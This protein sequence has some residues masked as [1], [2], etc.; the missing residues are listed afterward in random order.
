MYNDLPDVLI[1]DV[2]VD[3]VLQAALEP[4]PESVMQ[5]TPSVKEEAKNP[6][7]SLQMNGRAHHLPSSQMIAS[8]PGSAQFFAL[9][10]S[11]P[12]IS[13]S[14]SSS[15]VSSQ[16]VCDA[17]GLVLK[18]SSVFIRCAECVD[19]I[20]DLCVYCFGNGA[21][22]GSHKRSHA[23]VTVHAKSCQIF[24]H[25]KLISKL[26]IFQMLRIM[27]QVEKRGCFNFSDLEKSLAIAPGD[28]E[29]LYLEIVTLLSQ[30]D[31]THVGGSY[32]VEPIPEGLTGG[33]ANFNPLRDEFEHEYVPEA[34]TLLASVIPP[35]TS[36]GISNELISLFDGYNGILDERERRRKVLKS[37]KM[38]TLKDF[39]NVLKKRKTDE[40]E[41]FEKIRIFLRPALLA[42]SPDD[43]MS[44][45]E[46]LANSLTYRKRLID[47]VKRLLNLRRNGISSELKEALQFDLDRKK[48]N[49][50]NSRK[51]SAGPGNSIKIWTSLPTL[52]LDTSSSTSSANTLQG[53][54]RGTRGSNPSIP[55]PD[56]NNRFMTA[57]E[58]IQGLP[59]GSDA[60]IE[61]CTELQIA[62]QHLKAIEIAIHS[63][64]R[65]RGHDAQVDDSVLLSL[66]KEG[67]FGTIRR[68]LLAAQGLPVSAVAQ[69]ILS[70]DEMKLKL[71]QYCR[72]S[73]SP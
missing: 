20:I 66:I 4:P 15:A 28:G 40:K 12:S 31:E 39:F 53:I 30:C 32:Q 68:Y 25:S 41:M 60:P 50:I 52:N 2:F 11:P 10:S 51:I 56:E 59:G 69:N 27:E 67:V 19:P 46:S 26:N 70:Q 65:K 34:E 36:S 58:A 7:E 16:I 49:D 33:M 17:C 1:G 72:L 24:K 48:R 6:K 55:S 38:I 71:I 42:G 35:P 23:Y 14:S 22:F 43:C 62:P 5:Q 44:F 21:E 13:S 61:L 9:T 47:R 45:L 64:L 18:K 54:R 3:A 63:V 57:E 8:L 29:K 73:Y 37:A